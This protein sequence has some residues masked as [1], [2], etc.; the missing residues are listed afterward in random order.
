MD[1]RSRSPSISIAIPPRQ[2][3]SPSPPSTPRT[4]SPAPPAAAADPPHPRFPYSTA[5][6]DPPHP[7]HRLIKKLVSN[8]FLNAT[9]L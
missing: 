1:T 9:V 4:L 8:S 3:R 5:A 2:I 7:A 6:A